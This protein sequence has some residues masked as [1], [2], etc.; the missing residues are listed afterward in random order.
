MGYSRASL[1]GNNDVV[2]EIEAFVRFRISSGWW[3]RVLV[4]RGLRSLKDA[5]Q[6]G[7]YRF[8]T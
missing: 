4:I 3:A 8:D 6:L 2:L 7:C 5:L 1:Y